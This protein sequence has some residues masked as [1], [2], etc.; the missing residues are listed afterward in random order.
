MCVCVCVCLDSVVPTTLDHCKFLA[1]S[2]IANGELF[3][4][5]AYYIYIQGAYDKFPDFFAQAFK[6]GVD[7]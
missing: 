1:Y 4:N 6:I 5:K 7:S 2:I 3:I